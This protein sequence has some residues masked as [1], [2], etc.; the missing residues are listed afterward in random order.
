VQY[1][2]KHKSEVH[3]YLKSWYEEYIIP[4]RQ[5]SAQIQELQYIF[6]NTNI[7]EC[8]SNSTISFL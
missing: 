4:L 6:L 3:I 8:T 1:Y 7:G 2:I 5:T